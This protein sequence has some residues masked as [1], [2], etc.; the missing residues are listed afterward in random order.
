MRAALYINNRSRT[1]GW[2]LCVLVVLCHC[3]LVSAKPSWYAPS[4]WWP[5]PATGLIWSNVAYRKQMNLKQAKSYCS[6]L[7]LGGLSEWRLPTLVDQ[8][9]SSGQKILQ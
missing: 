8:H 6:A 7:T 5:D 1:A 3:S 2:C 9:G 4:A